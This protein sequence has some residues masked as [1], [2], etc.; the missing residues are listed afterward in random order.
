MKEVGAAQLKEAAK[1]R[2]AGDLSKFAEH[3]KSAAPL[4]V[5]KGENAGQRDTNGRKCVACG[6]KTYTLCGKCKVPL[7]FFNK[8]NKKDL[9]FLDYHDASFLGLAKCDS[10]L[11][12]ISKGVWRPSSQSARSVYR[13]QL[14]QRENVGAATPAKKA[15]LVRAST[16]EDSVESRSAAARGGR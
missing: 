15:R 4:L 10:C 8:K 9:C 16:T 1:K 11:V 14:G 5:Q 3:V 12:G 2:T 13:Q 6:K 7:C